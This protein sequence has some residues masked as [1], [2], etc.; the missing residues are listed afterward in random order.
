MKIPNHSGRAATDARSPI[1]QALHQSRNDFV[2]WVG[3]NP[4]KPPGGL[5]SNALVWL[6][7]TL[8]EQRNAGRYVVSRSSQ[9]TKRLGE[10]I[11]VWG[12]AIAEHGQDR[13]QSVS[14]G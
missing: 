6:F 9:M 1:P 14:S 4:A 10:E 2:V 7:Q 12:L 3:T 8:H 11:T 13:R 5:G